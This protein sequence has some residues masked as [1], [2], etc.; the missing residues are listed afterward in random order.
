MPRRPH[1][2]RSWSLSWVDRHPRFYIHHSLSGCIRIHLTTLWDDTSASSK[3]THLAT[4][5]AWCAVDRHPHFYIHHCLSG[6]SETPDHSNRRFLTSSK[7]EWDMFGWRS[8]LAP[9][10]LWG[11]ISD[12]PYY[13]GRFSSAPRLVDRNQHEATYQLYLNTLHQ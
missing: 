7:T 10:P 2:V 3:Y 8:S 5:M 1:N 11:K 12:C 9:K 6:V 13:R 4:Y